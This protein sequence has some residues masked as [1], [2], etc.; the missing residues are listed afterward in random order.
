MVNTQL[1]TPIRPKNVERPS[2]NQYTVLKGEDIK[3]VTDKS[4]S[5]LVAWVAREFVAKAN[6]NWR[7]DG[8]QFVFIA[9]E[10]VNMTRDGK[11]SL[12]KLLGDAV[13]PSNVSL[14]DSVKIWLFTQYLAARLSQ[15]AGDW[16]MDGWTEPDEMEG[17][18]AHLEIAAVFD[19]LVTEVPAAVSVAPVA[20]VLENMAASLNKLNTRV[21]NGG[22]T[23][24]FT[25]QGNTISY[26]ASQS[27]KFE[28]N[29]DL[30]PQACWRVVLMAFGYWLFAAIMT[31]NKSTMNAKMTTGAELVQGVTA[32]WNDPQ[33]LF[34]R[35]DW[36]MHFSYITDPKVPAPATQAAV[37]DG[38]KEVYVVGDLDGRLMPLLNMLVDQGLLT[39]EDSTGEMAWKAPK[40]TYVVQMGD[41]L[42]GQR[43]QAVGETIDPVTPTDLSL[44]LVMDYL[45]E[46]SDGRVRSLLGNHEIMNMQGDLRYVA[47]ENSRKLT[48]EQ[49][50][51]LLSMMQPL[52]RR[53]HFMLRI[54]DA[55]FSHAGLEVG[56]WQA[57]LKTSGQGQ[58]R[59]INRMIRSMNGL[60]GQRKWSAQEDDLFQKYIIGIRSER[61][62]G[63][64]WTRAF[65]RQG[66]DREKL[67]SMIE[68]QADK[69]QYPYGIIS[70]IGHNKTLTTEVEVYKWG[71]ER[72][73]VGTDIP[74][75]PNMPQLSG[76]KDYTV[77]PGDGYMVLADAFA[78]NKTDLPFAILRAGNDG[79]FNK[80]ET[81]VHRCTGTDKAEACRFFPLAQTMWK[82]LGD[83]AAPHG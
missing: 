22:F 77:V 65:S 19:G 50:N 57:W 5:G 6:D 49:R 9:G 44:V 7:V 37:I 13:T 26:A 4:L 18:N 54:N 64:V 8:L 39:I 42:D 79:R 60:L 58:P 20:P 29:M 53:R 66:D 33:Q 81:H 76:G 68:G 40:T 46:I 51:R 38:A 2:R 3:V 67:P 74:N 52:L 75:D 62:Q 15:L 30:V 80:I 34:C 14:T 63:L 32:L 28:L 12:I 21:T 45:Q 83:A 47:E 41:Q 25:A 69:A 11:A 73:I 24:G 31:T 43:V 70:V 48:T 1:V 61:F 71:N 59:D 35:R 55:L 82:C 10:G 27:P 56:A 78:L 17:K 23:A 36:H 72:R 16:A